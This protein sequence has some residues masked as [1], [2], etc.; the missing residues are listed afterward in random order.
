MAVDGPSANAVTPLKES[1]EGLIHL[2]EVDASAFREFFL[3]AHSEKTE[4]RKDMDI[5]GVVELAIWRKYT[6]RN[7]SATRPE[8][9]CGIS[10]IVAGGIL[11]PAIVERVYEAV[12]AGCTLRRLGA[13]GLGSNFK[14]DIWGTYDNQHEEGAWENVFALH[15]DLGWDFFQQCH[16]QRGVGDTIGS[17]DSCRSHVHE[18]VKVKEKGFG[19]RCLAAENGVST[20]G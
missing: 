9:S 12:P 16:G 13:V 7:I 17:G 3:W 11:T 14:K 19:G 18:G 4:V 5:A 8:I 1:S 15:T 6:L 10:W 20:H 2:L